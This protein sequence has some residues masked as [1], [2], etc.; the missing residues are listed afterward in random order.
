MDEKIEENIERLDF[1]NL[2]WLVFIVLSFL[3]IVGDEDEK[4]FLLTNNQEFKDE[5]NHIFTLTLTV[6]I[7][8]YLYFF[9]RNVTSLKNAPN[10]QKE[11]FTIKVLGSVFLI[12][13]IVFLLYFQ[14]RQTSFPGSPAI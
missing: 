2:L 5:S 6:T 10:N 8:V 9:N 14:T 7:F 3:N 4:K 1:E 13:G 12:I 11:L